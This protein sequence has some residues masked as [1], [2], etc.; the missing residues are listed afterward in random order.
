MVRPALT[1]TNLHGQSMTLN[2]L[3]CSCSAEAARHVMLMGRDLLLEPVFSIPAL[4]PAVNPPSAPPLPLAGALLA[5]EGF[6]LLVD[7]TRRSVEAELH[8][9]TTTAPTASSTSSRLCSANSHIVPVALPGSGGCPDLAASALLHRVSARVWLQSMQPD[10]LSQVAQALVVL[11]PH[12]SYTIISRF[13]I[14]CS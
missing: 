8:T 2:L 9:P 10:L 1:C 7:A 12:S 13:L 4:L 11:P 5:I 3:L 6:Y 14:A